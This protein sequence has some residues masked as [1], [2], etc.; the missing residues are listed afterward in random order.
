MAT[1]HVPASVEENN[2]SF[3][4]HEFSHAEREHMLKEDSTAFGTVS[5][6]LVSIVSL[7]FLLVAISVALIVLRS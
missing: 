5:L 1:V 3:W 2:R 7:G 6:E 4:T